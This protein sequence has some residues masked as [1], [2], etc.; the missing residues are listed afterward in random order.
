MLNINSLQ[1]FQNYGKG[2]LKRALCHAP[3][4]TDLIL[5]LAGAVL[6]HGKD[7]NVREYNGKPANMM[8]FTKGTK[9]YCFH[10]DHEHGK[11]KLFDRSFKGALITELD[12]KTT[13]Q[14]IIDL[15]EKL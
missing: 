2:V 14:D 3:N 8:W 13:N 7:I 9:R 6:I 4:V 5:P 10:Y 1:D 15:F 12:N 11:I